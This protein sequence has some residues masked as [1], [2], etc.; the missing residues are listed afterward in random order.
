MP[1]IAAGD[2][3]AG[4]PG[5]PDVIV[6]APLVVTENP[7]SVLLAGLRYWPGDIADAEQNKAW[8]SFEPQ[9]QSS[10]KPTQDSVD[11][12]TASLR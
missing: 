9:D 2:Q 3:T 12:W 5:M 8:I 11:A 7:N 4:N 10:G 6:L 1:R